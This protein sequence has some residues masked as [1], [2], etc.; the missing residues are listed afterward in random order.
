MCSRDEYKSNAFVTAT[1][2]CRRCTVHWSWCFQSSDTTVWIAQCLIALVKNKF[3]WRKVCDARIWC[4]ALLDL[5]S[6]IEFFGKYVK[7]VSSEND[8]SDRY[9]ANS[10]RAHRSEIFLQAVSPNMR[11]AYPMFRTPQPFYLLRN[12]IE[13]IILPTLLAPSNTF[14]REPWRSLKD[15]NHF[16]S[17]MIFNF[18]HLILLRLIG[19]FKRMNKKL[20]GL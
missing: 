17:R 20:I 6:G 19:H 18:T 13:V 1:C 7:W 10:T 9:A 4:R 5:L 8:A 2:C 3:E 12:A 15:Y 14:L 16:S 11:V